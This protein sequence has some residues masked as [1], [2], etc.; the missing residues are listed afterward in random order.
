MRTLYKPFRV[1]LANIHVAHWPPDRIDRSNV[2]DCAPSVS[3]EFAGSVEVNL[4]DL[5]SNRSRLNRGIIEDCA[6]RVA[7]V[8]QV[9]AS[10]AGR[11]DSEHEI[12]VIVNGA[13]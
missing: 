2:R 12:V 4:R 11:L 5:N 7:S 10:V 8:A 13:D 9:G 3:A 6:H 1:R